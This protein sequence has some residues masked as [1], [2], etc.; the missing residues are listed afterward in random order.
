MATVGMV[1]RLVVCANRVDPE[2]SLWFCS[3]LHRLNRLIAYLV[4]IQ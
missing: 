1:Y 4:I 3:A 2:I